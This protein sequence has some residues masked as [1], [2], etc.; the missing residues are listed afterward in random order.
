MAILNYICRKEDKLN[1]KVNSN[2]IIQSPISNNDTTIDDKNDSSGEK[3]KPS[4]YNNSLI[5][6]KQKLNE[7]FEKNERVSDK[8]CLGVCKKAG[9]WIF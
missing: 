9:C 5:N 1:A 4:C 3:I 2:E 7:S 6:M 8:A